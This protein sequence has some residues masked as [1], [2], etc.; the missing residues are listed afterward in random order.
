MSNDRHKYD[1]IINLPHH[2]SKKH[3]PMSLENRAA[4]FSPFAALTGYEGQVIEEARLTDKR[5]ELSD[6]EKERLDEKLRIIAE[7]LDERPTV[8]I[9]YFV[10]DHYKDGGSYTTGT[11]TVKKINALERKITFCAE[12]GVS[13]EHSILIENIIEIDGKVF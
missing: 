2:V 11:G 5:V 7:H 1:D 3:P 6:S 13:D 9:T 4:Q 8:S 12:N 10:P